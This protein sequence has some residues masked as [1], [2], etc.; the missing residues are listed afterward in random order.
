MV[1]QTEPEEESLYHI[2]MARFAFMCFTYLTTPPL[3]CDLIWSVLL[4]IC[5]T[6]MPFFHLVCMPLSPLWDTHMDIL[7]G[8]HC[9]HLL[10][11]S[12]S[13][14]LCLYY[15]W[16]PVSL[17]D[18]QTGSGCTS[19]RSSGHT[20]LRIFWTTTQH[21]LLFSFA[22]FSLPASVLHSSSVCPCSF[23]QLSVVLLAAV[24][25]NTAQY[26]F[27]ALFAA[28]LGLHCAFLRAAHRTALFT[29]HTALCCP[30]VDF[31]A[32]GSVLCSSPSI[33]RHGSCLP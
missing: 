18:R 26:C 15:G 2:L 13:A 4:S 33:T 3:M 27:P 31:T 30:Q 19:A 23:L 5:L 6:H 20:H 28:P 1:E 21:A 29:P 12:L 9:M 11:I 22:Q 24:A 32:V 7:S 14:V 16:I 8:H 17:D 25:Q 10:H